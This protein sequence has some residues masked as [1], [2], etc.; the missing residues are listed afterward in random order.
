MNTERKLS[1]SE[2]CA[3]SN[4]SFKRFSVNNQQ[5]QGKSRLFLYKKQ[6]C[7]LIL[8]DRSKHLCL[9]LLV[10]TCTIAYLFMIALVLY[11]LTVVRHLFSTTHLIPA[12]HRSSTLL[13]KFF[14]GTTE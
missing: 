13:R 4:L 7:A 12:T 11:F 1:H 8:D 10:R 6:K 14:K 2:T 3:F 5:E 9:P